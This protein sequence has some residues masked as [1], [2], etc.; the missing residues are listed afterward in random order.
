MESSY[1]SSFRK[2]VTEIF[3]LHQSFSPKYAMS[4]TVNTQHDHVHIDLLFNSHFIQISAR[5]F[6]PEFQKKS[7]FDP[8]RSRTTF[9]SIAANGYN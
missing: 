8:D 1:L 3:T 5:Q 9:N 6:E 2:F 7:R 4:P